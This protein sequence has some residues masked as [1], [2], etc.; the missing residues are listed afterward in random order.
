[1]LNTNLRKLHENEKQGIV[2]VRIL[3]NNHTEIDIEIQLSPLRVW[4][5][6]TGKKAGEFYTP[7]GPA[8]ILC[9]IAISG[10]EEKKDYRCMTHVWGQLL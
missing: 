4:A 2:D 7:H 3:M 5:S 10:Q 1:M 6:E 8:Q 9:R